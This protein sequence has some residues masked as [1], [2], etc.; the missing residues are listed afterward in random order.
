ME[1]L[2]EDLKV[3]IHIEKD[4]VQFTHLYFQS[5]CFSFS[6]PPHKLS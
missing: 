3:E 2:N 5:I 4:H 6:L 1:E